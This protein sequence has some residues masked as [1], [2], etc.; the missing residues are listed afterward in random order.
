M[1]SSVDGRARATGGAGRRLVRAP[2]SVMRTWT[3][4]GDVLRDRQEKR[5]QQE[6][7]ERWERTD[8]LRG[9]PPGT[10]KAREEMDRGDEWGR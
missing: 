10:A 8:R 5:R 3:E 1:E 4:I 9:D 2:G 7:E 6:R